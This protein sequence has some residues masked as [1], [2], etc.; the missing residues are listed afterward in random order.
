MMKNAFYFIQNSLSV[1]KI[2]IF[3]ILTQLEKRL[4]KESNI[5]MKLPDVTI[6]LTNNYK[7]KYSLTFQEVKVINH[8]M[9]LL[10]VSK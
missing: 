8:T 5:N 1:L 3:F 7:K 10:M 2:F 4:D 9:K 6:S